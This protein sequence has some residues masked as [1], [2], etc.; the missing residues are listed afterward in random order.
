MSVETVLRA[1]LV[2]DGGV[3]ALVGTRIAA[4][5]IEQGASR[6]FVVFSRTATAPITAVDGALLISQV[7]IDVQCWADTRLQAD[8]VADAVSAAVRGVTSQQVTER[9]SVYDAD[10]D[11]EGTQLSVEWWE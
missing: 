7:S 8:A 3:S 6:P 10:L 5:R 9:S 4:D 2:A 1:L 11:M